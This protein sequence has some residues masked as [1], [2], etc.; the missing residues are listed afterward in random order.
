M[1]K[2]TTPPN[3]EPTR[4]QTSEALDRMILDK[5]ATP[6]GFCYKDVPQAQLG[7]AYNHSATLTTAGLIFRGRVDRKVRFFDSA[8]RA[9][10]W[11][12]DTMLPVIQLSR[13]DKPASPRADAVTSLMP[14]YKYTVYPTPTPKNTTYYSPLV[15]TGMRAMS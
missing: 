15:R 3:G 1:T 4:R 5:C 2:I 13:L 12:L 9:E 7:A 10:A 11:R 14:G 6:Q 8:A